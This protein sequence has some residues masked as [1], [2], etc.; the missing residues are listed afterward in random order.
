MDTSFESMFIKFMALFEGC[1][2]TTNGLF[3][4]DYVGGT[5]L[6]PYS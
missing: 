3:P 1:A 5:I 4:Y 6:S 2:G